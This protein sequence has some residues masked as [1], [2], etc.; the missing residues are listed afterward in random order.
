MAK[1][2][3]DMGTNINEAWRYAWCPQISSCA[4]AYE[5]AEASPTDMFW[6]R[7]RGN[8][9]NAKWRFRVFARCLHN[10][11]PAGDE[12][13]RVVFHGTGSSALDSTI[14]VISSTG[15]E[16]QEYGVWYT[17]LLTDSSSP[18]TSPLDLKVQ[19]YAP[20]YTVHVLAFMIY[21]EPQTAPGADVLESGFVR[22]NSSMNATND[23]ITSEQVNRLRQAPYKIASTRPTTLYSN[24][25]GYYTED[26]TYKSFISTAEATYQTVLRSTIPGDGFN[27]TYR[28]DA[29]LR[30]EGRAGTDMSVRIN[31]PDGTLTLTGRDEWKTGT[32]ESSQQSIPFTAQIKNDDDDD[33][34][35]AMPSLIIRREPG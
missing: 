16:P 20:V 32:F 24:F 5:S 22:W 10:E 12:E 18:F 6:V 14:N 21:L 23:P 35:V 3:G 27:R 30:D 11:G 17:S 7:L 13:V 2:I 1:A 31:T 28:V 8:D 33:E 29:Y 19:I 34:R 15:G 9:D 25:S 4:L 26:A